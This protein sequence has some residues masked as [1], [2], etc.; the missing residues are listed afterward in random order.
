V[1]TPY[2]KHK[3]TINKPPHS[4]HQKIKPYSNSP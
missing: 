4:Q 2:S 1:N 3:P